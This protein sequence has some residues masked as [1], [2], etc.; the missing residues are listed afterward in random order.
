MVAVVAYYSFVRSVL[1]STI[2]GVKV[3]SKDDYRVWRD[4]ELDFASV[5][6]EAVLGFI[7]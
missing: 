2:P 4:G 5:I 7:A 3:A 6:V 1:I